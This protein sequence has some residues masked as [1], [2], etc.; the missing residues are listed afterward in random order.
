[1]TEICS[2][3][4]SWQSNII[5]ALA[6]FLNLYLDDM[7]FYAH[8]NWFFDFE[9][10]FWY[11]DT[12]DNLWYIDTLDALD[13]PT[14]S[15]LPYFDSTPEVL[16][17]SCQSLLC[18]LALSGEWYSPPTLLVLCNQR[19]GDT[20]LTLTHTSQYRRHDIKISINTLS[21]LPSLQ[22]YFNYSISIRTSVII[23][24]ALTIPDKRDGSHRTP[25]AQA[26]VPGNGDPASF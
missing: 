20:V 8:T 5:L 18:L 25:A 14:T 22:L 21:C 11:S 10:F 7:R 9:Y 6:I 19:I 2:L 26:S 16:N 13:Y 23:N 4:L 17:L 3:L 12:M 1:M 15:P 24:S